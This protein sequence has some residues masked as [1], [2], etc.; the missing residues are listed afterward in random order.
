M[1]F[2]VLCGR[3]VDMD[4]R[5]CLS[6]NDAWSLAFAQQIPPPP[7]RLFPLGQVDSYNGN[8]RSELC[9]RDR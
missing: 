4:E 3:L 7:P 6:V 2:G 9:T 8:E 5:R 1:L